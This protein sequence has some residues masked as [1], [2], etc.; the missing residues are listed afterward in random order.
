MLKK[1]SV[2]FYFFAFILITTTASAANLSQKYDFLDSEFIDENYRKTISLDFRNAPLEDVLKMF[3][4]QAGWNFIASSEVSGV[5]LNVYLDKVPVEEALERILS[6]KGLT[7]ELY[8]DSNIF[9][10]KPLVKTDRQL[11]TRVYRLKNASVPKASINTTLDDITT[12]PSGLTD[13]IKALLSPKG[14]MVEDPRTNSLIVSD[15]ADQIPLV[16]QALSRLDVKIPQILIECEI[17]DTKKGDAEEIGIKWGNPSNNEGIVMTNTPGTLQT[18]W[19]FDQDRLFGGRNLNSADWEVPKLSYTAGTWALV[20]LGQKLQLLRSDT[21][22]KTLARPRIITLNNQMAKIEISTDQVIGTKTV[23]DN[24]TGTS[25]DSIERASTGVK[26]KVTPQAN[27]DSGEITLAVQPEVINATQ[28]T[29]DPTTA[30]PETRGSKSITRVMS[31]DT[32]IIGG[33]IRTEEQNTSYSVPV[34]GAIPL[35]G[36][37]FK[38]DNRSKV[39]R[40][41]IIFLTPNIIEDSSNL[42]T[43]KSA[44]KGFPLKPSLEREQDEPISL[45]MKQK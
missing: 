39:D 15:T 17:L 5:K 42:M 38:H 27:I 7:Y 4:Q 43:A 21:D 28:S 31:G 25:T 19:P 26:L 13:A 29:L 16:E 3:A 18:F 37:A 24:V 33:L 34:L 30:E 1:V 6:A 32:L 14:S 2:I 8:P 23:T 11:V 44:N 10:V 12:E 9:T 22:T 35:I 20:G 40:E 45:G 41:L 36:R